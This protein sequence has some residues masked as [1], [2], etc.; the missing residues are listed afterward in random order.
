MNILNFFP[1]GSLV[2]HVTY[3]SSKKKQKKNKTLSTKLFVELKV[4][5]LKKR[6]NTFSVQ[7]EPLNKP[8]S[9]H[10]LDL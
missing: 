7:M 6:K 8:I 4:Y 9:N 10:T 3:S 1:P 2:K 5:Y